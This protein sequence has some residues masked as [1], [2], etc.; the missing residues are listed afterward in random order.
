[1]LL[2]EVKM[3]KERLTPEEAQRATEEKWAKLME[4]EST[5][6]PCGWCQWA[7][8]CER[9]PVPVVFGTNVEQGCS[10]IP[11]YVAWINAVSGLKAA[12]VVHDL[13]VSKRE[14]LIAAAKE[15]ERG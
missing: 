15:L 3:S 7:S 5:D 6:L 11:E 12:K 2:R 14:E 9:C 13:L 4:E 8:G 10:E 1:M